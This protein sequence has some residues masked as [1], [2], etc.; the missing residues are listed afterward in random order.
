MTMPSPMEPSRSRGAIRKLPMRTAPPPFYAEEEKMEQDLP[1]A[2]CTI[3]AETSAGRQEEES[4][5]IRVSE[6]IAKAP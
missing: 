3:A 2:P 6:W 5:P 4:H 1:E